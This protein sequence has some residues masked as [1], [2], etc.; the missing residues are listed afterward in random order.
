MVFI[1]KIILKDFFNIKFNKT[2]ILKRINV[3]IGPNGSGK[4]GFLNN[5][6]NKKIKGLNKN[7]EKDLE[8]LYKDFC[9]DMRT[10]DN[11]NN[12]DEFMI[13]V[14]SHFQSRGE[15]S[16]EFIRGLSTI[17]NKLIMMDEPERGLDIDNLNILIS[18]IKKNKSC[19]FIIATHS[20]YLIS[21][22]NANIIEMKKGYLDKMKIML[23]GRM[24]NEN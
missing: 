5:I 16:I 15:T 17:K 20:P 8:F 1:T 13:G 18:E 23:G 9:E 24:K 19:Q 10:K 3:L 7:S 11:N 2:Y 22:F 21:N 14:L 6:K 4:S 12:N